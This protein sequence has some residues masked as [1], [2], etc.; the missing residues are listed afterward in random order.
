LGVGYSERFKGSSPSWAKFFGDKE[1]SEFSDIRNN[2]VQIKTGKYNINFYIFIIGEGKSVTLAVVSMIL[3]LHGFEVK[4]ACYSKYL[5]DRD[6]NSFV[7]MFK[8]LEVDDLIK[9]GT[10]NEVSEMQINREG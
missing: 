9:Y 6:Y 8:F 5:S 7:D 10:F 1:D 4:C 2:L 3:A